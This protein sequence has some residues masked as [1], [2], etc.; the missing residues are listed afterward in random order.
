MFGRRNRKLS[1]E[2][3]LSTIDQ[4]MEYYRE[5]PNNPAVTSYCIDPVS[6]LER[7]KVE[8]GLSRRISEW[9]R[10]RG[11]KQIPSSTLSSQKPPN[12]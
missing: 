11:L 5:L 10:E 12:K 3:V 6:V 1:E 2:F 4:T 7:L 9:E 8:L